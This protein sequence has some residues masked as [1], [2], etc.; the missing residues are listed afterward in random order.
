LSLDFTWSLTTISSTIDI[1]SAQYHLLVQWAPH[2]P[3]PFGCLPRRSTPTRSVT[4]VT[5]AARSLIQ[6][7]HLRRRVPVMVGTEIRDFTLSAWVGGKSFRRTLPV[8][9]SGSRLLHWASVLAAQR[10]RDA[11]H[12]GSVTFIP[13]IGSHVIS[14]GQRSVVV[15]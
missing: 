14:F 4:I 9:P 3:V 8:S 10:Y 5:P 6:V 1:Y 11:G 12:P 2:D 7:G 15:N 13:A